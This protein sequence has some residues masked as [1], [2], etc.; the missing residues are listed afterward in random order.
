LKSLWVI[1]GKKYRVKRI[2]VALHMRRLYALAG[3][4]KERE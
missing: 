4:F 1:I 3:Y 2:F